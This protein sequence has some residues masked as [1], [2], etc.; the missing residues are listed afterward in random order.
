MDKQIMDLSNSQNKNTADTDFMDLNIHPHQEDH[1]HDVGDGGDK[2]DE[3]LPNYDFQ[4]IRPIV[5]SQLSNFESSNVGGARVWSSAEFEP[6]F[7]ARVSRLHLIFVSINVLLFRI[8]GFVSIDPEI[9][10][11][12]TH[13]SRRLESAIRIRFLILMQLILLLLG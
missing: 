6:N 8:C 11:S 3:I 9:Y 2:K 13:N 7:G 10:W 1:H 4:P 5:S 12:L